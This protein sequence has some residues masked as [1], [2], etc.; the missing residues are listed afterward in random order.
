MLQQVRAIYIFC[1]PFIFIIFIIILLYCCLLFLFLSL[2]VVITH[3]IYILL[4]SFV[5]A[6]SCALLWLLLHQWIDVFCC[7][8]SLF[9]NMCE[10]YEWVY[11]FWYLRFLFFSQLRIVK[12]LSSSNGIK[13]KKTYLKKK[14]TRH[15]EYSFCVYT[16]R[17]TT[18]R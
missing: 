5:V 2:L 16:E 10:T 1:V 6:L 15:T 13:R 11:L 12:Q 4:S 7:C 3:I 17:D 9:L 14:A 18:A 8:C